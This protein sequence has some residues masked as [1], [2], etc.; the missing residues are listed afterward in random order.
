MNKETGT[1]I[2]HST[3]VA[4]K[5]PVVRRSTKGHEYSTDNCIS[6]LALMI[7]IP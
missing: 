4:A 2:L 1:E 7:G 6:N 5:E 3:W